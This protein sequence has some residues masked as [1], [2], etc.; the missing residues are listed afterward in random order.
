[1]NSYSL[2]IIYLCTYNNI[3]E[4]RTNIAADSRVHAKLL[5]IA[6]RNRTTVY[7][8]TNS[9]LSICA[10]AIE[11]GLTIEDLKGQ[12]LIRYA[13]KN[14]DVVL[15]PGSLIEY[16]VN[17]LYPLKKEEM[18]RLFEEAGAQL[19]K[20]FKIKGLTFDDILEMAKNGYSSIGLRELTVNRISYNRVKIS[21][22]GLLLGR[23][24]TEVGL[25]FVQ[26]LLNE[27][28][29]R[30]INTELAEGAVAVDCE[31]SESAASSL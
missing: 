20:Y 3:R 12:T 29:F 14:L 15:L 7:E 2:H 21:I 16:M 24:A 17:Q 6:K 19:G 30:I 4:M 13:V 1:M 31:V 27:F 11:K 9:L 26:G 28:G 8:L 5:Q 25:K 22:Y 23:A 18:S 10:D